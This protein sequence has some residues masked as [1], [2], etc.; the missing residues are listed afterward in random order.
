M[1]S[2]GAKVTALYRYPVKSARCEPIELARVGPEGILG[3]R[4]LMVV[5]NDGD[6]LRVVTQRDVPRLALVEP[7]IVGNELTLIFADDN[8]VAAPL[9]RS[10]DPSASVRARLFG[11]DVPAVDLGDHVAST[12]SAQLGAGGRMRYRLVRAVEPR[13]G[14]P[15]GFADVAPIL[16]LS[17]ESLAELNVRRAEARLEPVE[18]ARFRPNIVVQGCT[19]AFA[20][21]QWRFPLRIG[22]VV[23]VSGAPCPRCTV[24]DVCQ[25]TGSVAGRE[26][27]PMRTLRSFRKTLSGYVN[28]GMY[29]YPAPRDDGDGCAEAPAIRVGDDVHEFSRVDAADVSDSLSDGSDANSAA[30]TPGGLGARLRGLLLPW[31]TYGNVF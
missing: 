11:V 4:R 21:D 29:L 23:F 25:E 26:E 2:T 10:S 19:T 13:S 30:L 7:R 16:A 6:A 9:A 14:R 28:L 31:A 12:L 15:A 18:M 27:S 5:R 17:E 3:D 22:E 1:A 24:P 8:T 20:E